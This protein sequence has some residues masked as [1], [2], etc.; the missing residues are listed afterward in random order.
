MH[1]YIY[2]YEF[3]LN[4]GFQDE[5]GL[6]LKV[7]SIPTKKKRR[8]IVWKQTSH[9]TRNPNLSNYCSTNVDL[10]TNNVEG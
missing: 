3:A 2:M 6:C 7:H 9:R 5:E 4:C 10:E 1:I 8:Y